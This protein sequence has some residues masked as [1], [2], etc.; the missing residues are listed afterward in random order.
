[1]VLGSV[2]PF[3][4]FLPS[5]W[6]NLLFSFIP[7]QHMICCSFKLSSLFLALL[8]IFFM[9]ESTFSF[10]G[11]DGFFGLKLQAGII[12]ILLIEWMGYK[13]V[14]LLFV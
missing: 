7:P 11:Y 10:E 6:F 5:D 14:L 8:I 1:M 3:F 12:L 4:L 2:L 13:Q 9:G